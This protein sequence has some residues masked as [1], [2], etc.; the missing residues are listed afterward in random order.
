MR[1]RC[2]WC[3]I[4][5]RAAQLGSAGLPVAVVNPRQVRDF[6]KCIGKLA[7]TDCIDAYVLARFAETNRPEPKPLPTEDEKLVK[8]LIGRRRQLI[9][10]RASEKNRL[11]RVRS[12][13]VGKSVLIVIETLTREIQEI[14]HDLDEIIK[15][16]PLWREDEE[17]L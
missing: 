1:E 6:A 15:Q 8:G 3:D 14:D 12:E 10:L 7:R 11:R 16:S 13:R 5:D 2:R 4:T 9:D 17:L